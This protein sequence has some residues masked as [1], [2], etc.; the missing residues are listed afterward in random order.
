MRVYAKLHLKSINIQ[1]LLIRTNYI[2]ITEYYKCILD[3]TSGE[4]D[5]NRYFTHNV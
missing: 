5:L 3:Q 1:L 4:E 2:L